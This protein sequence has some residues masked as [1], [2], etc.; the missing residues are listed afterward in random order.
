MSREKKLQDWKD[1]VE[2]VSKYSALMEAKDRQMAAIDDS[3]PPERDPVP[4]ETLHNLEIPNLAVTVCFFFFSF[5]YD[6]TQI[7]K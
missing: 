7:K 3:R 2:R 5:K 4:F 1:Y 6:F